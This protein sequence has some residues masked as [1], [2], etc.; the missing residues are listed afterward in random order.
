M[1]SMTG[2][3]TLQQAF[4][5]FE[6]NSVRVP[7][8]EIDAAKKAQKEGCRTATRSS[9]SRSPVTRRAT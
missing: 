9:A 2:T 4:E 5:Q 7:V 1:T 8:H 3:T 6:R